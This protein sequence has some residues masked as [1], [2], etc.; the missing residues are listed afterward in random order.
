MADCDCKQVLMLIEQ[1]DR[2]I[3]DLED[4]AKVLQELQTTFSIIK[5]VSLTVVTLM[6]GVATAS[7]IK[8]MEFKDIYHA[9]MMQL[10]KDVTALKAGGGQCTNLSR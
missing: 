3:T 7:Y 2:R 5:W 8:L 6:L 9:D 1:Q 4:S 10:Q